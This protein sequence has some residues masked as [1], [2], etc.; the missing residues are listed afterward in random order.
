MNGSNFV[1]CT[2]S[3]WLTPWKMS[4][5]EDKKN[6]GRDKYEMTGDG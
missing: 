5:L 4:L 3:V 2:K 1:K 6:I